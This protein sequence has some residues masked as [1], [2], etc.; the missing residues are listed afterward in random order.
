MDIYMQAARAIQGSLDGKGQLKRLCLQKDVQKKRATYAVAAETSKH[1]PILDEILKVSGFYGDNATFWPCLA[2]VM[3]Y[4]TLF[5]SGLKGNLKTGP[6]YAVKKH[7]S[8]MKNVM[9]EMMKKRKLTEPSQLIAKTAP[10]RIPIYVRVNTLVAEPE[11]VIEAF[12]ADGWKMLET[13]DAQVLLDAAKPQKDAKR[14]RS[15]KEAEEEPETKKQKVDGKKKKVSKKKAA[16]AQEAAEEEDPAVNRKIFYRDPTLTSLLVFPPSAK[17]YLVNH[18][19]LKT[20]KA[21]IQDKASCLPPYLLLHCLEM[22]SLLDK[23]NDEATAGTTFMGPVLDATAAPGNK[24]SLLAALSR[25]RRPIIAVERD[26]ERAVVLKE[27]L[28]AMKADKVE[29]LVQSFL[30]CMPEDYPNVEGILLDPSCSGSGIVD[31][32]ELSA[33]K[34]KEEE[35]E[36]VEALAEFQSRMVLH[37]MTFPSVRRIVYSTCSINQ[38]ENE[39]VVRTVINNEDVKGKW[40][41]A[42]VMPGTWSTRALPVLQDAQHCIRCSPKEDFT[43]G[44]F[45]AVFEKVP[46]KKKKR[47]NKTRGGVKHQK[48]KEKRAAKKMQEGSDDELEVVVEGGSDSDSD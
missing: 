7:T 10:P 19:V 35:V 24:T 32:I 6:G 44:F 38:T 28:K 27:R 33:A 26:E 12:K 25:G 31:R 13:P 20:N 36:R 42:D 1:M 21:V 3:V 17:F 15:V 9:N 37:A 22:N 46:S 16:A 5:G 14:K 29:V 48:Q 40:G 30:D 47:N 45:V 41:L 34:T 11:T 2:R 43:N 4:D 18:N 8:K 23:E 39:D